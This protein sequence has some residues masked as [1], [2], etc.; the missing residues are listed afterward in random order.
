MNDDL[1][2]LQHASEND[3]PPL[4]SDGRPYRKPRVL[5]VVEALR[6]SITSGEI[7]SGERLVELKVARRLNVSQSTVREAL[8]IL[9]QEGW[10]VK[11]PRHG[12]RV[13]AFQPADV[14]EL[15]RLLGMIESYALAKAMAGRSKTA[16][17]RLRSTLVNARALARDGNYIA[18]INALFEFHTQLT[19]VGAGPFAQELHTMMMNRARLLENVRQARVPT[20]P[21]ELERQLQRHEAIMRLIQDG[22]VQEAIDKLREQY[23]AY[24]QV[25]QQAIRD[26]H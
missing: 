14:D 19:Q 15:Y 1:T 7:L 17:Q 8:A 9:E 2:F 3:V 20:T 21:D 24:R 23:D 11:T 22:T 18:A 10:V 26:A 16:L 13:R 5:A 6:T 4:P 12:V 25:V